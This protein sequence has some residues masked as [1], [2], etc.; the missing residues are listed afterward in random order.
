MYD[1][2]LLIGEKDGLA[3]AGGAAFERLNPVTGDLATRAISHDAKL[4]SALIDGGTSTSLT[5]PNGG[6]VTV[7]CY[8][9]QPLFSAAHK[10]GNVTACN[11][12]VNA[13][14]TTYAGVLGK[15]VGTGTPTNPSPAVVALAIQHATAALYGFKGHQGEPRKRFPRE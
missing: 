7:A 11:N 13:N 10:I 8:D 9:G 14:L 12:I 15:A 2:G 5:I 3:A 6:N 4:L 1:I